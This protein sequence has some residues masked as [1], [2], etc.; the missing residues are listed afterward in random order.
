MRIDFATS[1][2]GGK[3]SVFRKVALLVAAFSIT[4]AFVS[5]AMNPTSGTSPARRAGNCS[6]WDLFVG[7]EAGVGVWSGL[8]CDGR[9]FKEDMFTFTFSPAACHACNYQIGKKN[10]YY[11]RA[12]YASTQWEDVASAHSLPN[13]FSPSQ[14]LIGATFFS[15]G[16]PDNVVSSALLPSQADVALFVVFAGT[17]ADTT[18]VTSTCAI[19]ATSN[20]TPHD[21]AAIC[22]VNPAVTSP[23]YD[24][25]NYAHMS[26]IYSST[27][28]SFGTGPTRL[29]VTASSPNSVNSTCTLTMHVA[30]PSSPS[31][32]WHYGN[33][34]WEGDYFETGLESTSA[35]ITA[36]WYTP[37]RA[38]ATTYYGSNPLSFAEWLTAPYYYTPYWVPGCR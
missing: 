13:A 21:E 4:S 15:P 35:T 27:M 7:Q 2:V 36:S 30:G 6:T 18:T 34:G 28:A 23:R 12:Y 25:N 17:C 20:A 37:Y 9:E 3:S 22:L 10:V 24:C 8:P 31:L 33:L 38:S 26:A 29:Y 32:E 1:H 14:E 5:P 11:V 16:V 19:A